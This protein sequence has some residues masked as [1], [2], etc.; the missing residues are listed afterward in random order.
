MSD[1]NT[2]CLCSQCQALS[3]SSTSREQY[4]KELRM[5]LESWNNWAKE[6]KTA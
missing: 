1:Y 2:L 6:G 4:Q 5:R 3:T